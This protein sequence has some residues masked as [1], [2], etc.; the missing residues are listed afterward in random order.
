M[1]T[2]TSSFKRKGVLFSE[3]HLNLASE[4]H[5]INFDVESALHYVDMSNVANIS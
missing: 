2:V 1:I 3:K 5:F 4:I